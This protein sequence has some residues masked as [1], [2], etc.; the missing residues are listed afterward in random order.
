MGVVVVVGMAAVA[1]VVATVHR[2]GRPWKSGP[3]LRRSWWDDEAVVPAIE[4]G[5]PWGRAVS[6]RHFIAGKCSGVGKEDGVRPRNEGA[7]LEPRRLAYLRL[8]NLHAVKDDQ[9]N[10]MWLGF[11][12]RAIQCIGCTRIPKAN[13]DRINRTAKT[14]L[15]CVKLVSLDLYWN[16]LFNYAI[17]I[18][19]FFIYLEWILVKEKTRKTT[20]PYITSKHK[21]YLAWPAY[22]QSTSR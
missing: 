8:G 5:A 2:L 6:Q 18:P 19:T 21:Y 1:V 13:F 20:A 10:L 17:I 9:W 14:W 3:A 16:I 7:A 22:M 15:Y 12:L 11:H 4:V